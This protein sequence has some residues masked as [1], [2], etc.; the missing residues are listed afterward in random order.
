[1]VVYILENLMPC[2]FVVA[3]TMCSSRSL[4]SLSLPQIRR[5]LRGCQDSAEIKSTC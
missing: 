2:V 5:T 4:F 3:D 1:M